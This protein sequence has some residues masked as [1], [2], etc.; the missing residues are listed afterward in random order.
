MFRAGVEACLPGKILARHLPEPP[1]GRTILLAVG[2]A[3]MGMA[4]AAERDWPGELAGLAVVPHGTP[5]SLRRIETMTAA[6][7]VPDGASLAA[8]ERLLALAGGAG[9]DDLVL[10][11]LS[12]GASALAAAPAP[13]LMLEAKR[14]LTEALLRSGAGIGEINIVRRHLSRLKGGRLGEAAQPARLVTLAI[15]DVPGDRP[16]DIGS[17]PTVA[18]PS[19]A[20]AAA[21]VLARYGL[22]APAPFIESVKPDAAAGSRGEYRIVARG[23]DAIEAASTA[24]AALGYR[25]V[26]VDPCA[27]GEAGSVARDHA[28]LALAA[29]PGSVLISGGELGVAV[30]GTGRGGRNAHYALALALA[31]RGAPGIHALAGDTDG[32]DGNCAAAGAFIDPGTLARAAALRRDPARALAECDAGGLFEAMG[33]A[34]TTGPTGTNV[35]DLRIILVDP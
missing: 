12:G 7:P 1:P 13:G 34:L 23:G 32:I 27:T 22:S 30:R 17:G 10:V 25:P 26:I 16:E 28:A 21:A 35:N 20:A 18:D 19:T 3:A 14:A 31:L 5:G 11:L 9:A 15:S 24:A 33:D 29:A 2:K 8:G 4:A 6:H